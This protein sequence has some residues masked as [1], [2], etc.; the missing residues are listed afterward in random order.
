MSF[1]ITYAYKRKLSRVEKEQ[2][3]KLE[4]GHPSV[5][6]YIT[7]TKE[8]FSERPNHLVRAGTGNGRKPKETSC[9]S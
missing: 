8:Q 1:G 9:I 5:K 2:V 6:S 3:R 7:W 4:E